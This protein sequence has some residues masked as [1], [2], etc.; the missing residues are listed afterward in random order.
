MRCQYEYCNG[1]LIKDECELDKQ[2]KPKRLICLFCGR[3][4][5]LDGELIT[6]IKSNEKVRW[7][8]RQ[9]VFV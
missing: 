6:E 2:G 4:H 1:N 8:Y 9:K 3:G 5:T 7:G